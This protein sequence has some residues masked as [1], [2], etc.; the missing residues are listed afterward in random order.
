MPQPYNNGQMVDLN[1]VIDPVLG[2]I[3]NAAS[4]INDEGQIVANSSGASARALLLTPVPEPG[5]RP[6]LGGAVRADRGGSREP[7]IC[8]YH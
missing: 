6:F 2:V 8:P 1:T 3:L 7:T 5:T 4:S